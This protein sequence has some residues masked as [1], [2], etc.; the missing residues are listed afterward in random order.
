MCNYFSVYGPLP[1]Y[2][3][4]FLKEV[5][6]IHRKPLT[7]HLIFTCVPGKIGE[8]ILLEAMLRHM[9]NKEVSGDSQHS[10]T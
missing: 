6:L 9:E 10:F 7:S 5:R 2:H 3:R 1:S 8:Q 4:Q